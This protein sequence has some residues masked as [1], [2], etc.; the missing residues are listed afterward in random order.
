MFVYRRS[1]INENNS[2]MSD[3]HLSRSRS[4]VIIIHIESEHRVQ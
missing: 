1:K 2:I 4:A 3:A